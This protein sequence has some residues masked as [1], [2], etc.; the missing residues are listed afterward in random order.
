[1]QTIDRHH[2]ITIRETHTSRDYS[3]YGDYATRYFEIELV[4]D[5]TILASITTCLDSG[6]G[7]GPTSVRIE[8][9]DGGTYSSIGVAYDV[10]CA[11][12]HDWELDWE[13]EI[14]EDEDDEEI[15]LEGGYQEP[16]FR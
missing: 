7:D 11:R 1:M 5:S 8:G 4:C 15:E 2:G 13:E 14:E 10:M 12:A 9:W 6:R 16:T 3:K